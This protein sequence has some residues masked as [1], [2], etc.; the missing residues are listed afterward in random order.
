[1]GIKLVLVTKSVLVTLVMYEIGESANLSVLLLAGRY[2]VLTLDSSLLVLKLG[3]GSE[4][5]QSQ[6]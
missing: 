2:V 1:M 6:F 4:F 5:L 3:I